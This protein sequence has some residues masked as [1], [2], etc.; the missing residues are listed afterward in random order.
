MSVKYIFIAALLFFGVVLSGSAVLNKA[1]AGTITVPPYACTVPCSVF[2]PSVPCVG[3]QSTQ[4]AVDST[5]YPAFYNQMQ[6]S[7]NNLANWMNN[8][9]NQ[10]IEALLVGFDDIVE[11][12]FQDWMDNWWANDYLPALQDMTGQINAAFVD[13]TRVTGSEMDATLMN[14]HLQEQ[15]QQE[16]EARSRYEPS[17]ATCPASGSMAGSFA[18]SNAVNRAFRQASERD[19][20]TDQTNK[21]GSKYENGPTDAVRHQW[22]RYCQNLVSPGTNDGMTGCAPGSLAG[23]LASE[24]TQNA[25]IE[26]G[27]F[28]FNN[29]TI[30]V[31]NPNEAAALEALKEN[32]VGI[33]PNSPQP[34]SSL[35]T[36]AGRNQFLGKRSLVARKNA[37][38][39]P[40]E[41]ITSQ[42]LPT[43]RIG[44]LVETL[45][46]DAGIPLS[47]LS[48]NP[49]YKEILHAVSTEKFTN[50][51]YHMDSADT[52]ENMERESLILSVFYLIQLREYYELL[53]RGVL[54]LAVQTSIDLDTQL[55]QASAQMGMPTSD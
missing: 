13:Q 3:T 43:S 17:D 11:Q 16:K 35:G 50:G 26:P 49:S 5:V 14:R 32:L 23:S 41:Y 51:H 4:T 27:R 44:D 10:F 1:Q 24:E 45:R 18:R 33:L 39:A 42:R 19:H 9:F 21:L 30:D 48:D 46:V 28:L 22:D 55:P 8:R 15:A 31:R 53:E 6:T 36:V 20:N 52:I 54:A 40:I 12:G 38:R 37:A 25:D 47:G 29:L 7:F 34:E 2:I